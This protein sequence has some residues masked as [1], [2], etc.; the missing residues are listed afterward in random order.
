MS[1]RRVA[2]N[3]LFLPGHPLLRNGYVVLEGGMVV[4]VVDTG[5]VM[6]E[7]PRLEFYGGLV[8]DAVACDIAD[9][10]PGDDIL[11]RLAERYAL[12]ATGSL[13]LVEGADL[14]LF[15]WL[16]TTRVTRLR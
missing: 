15:R 9:W 11:A 6:R 16:P 8:V 14:A 5:G 12:S 7:L 3:C 13:A 10:R 4:D 1:Q 2:A